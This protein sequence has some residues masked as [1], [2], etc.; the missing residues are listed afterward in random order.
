MERMVVVVAVGL[1]GIGAVLE[2]E[3]HRVRLVAPHGDASA[4]GW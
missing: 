4:V 3:A 1:I 2:E